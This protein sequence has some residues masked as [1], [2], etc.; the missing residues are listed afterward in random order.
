MEE[1][2]R[3]QQGWVR[4]GLGRESRFHSKYD[5]GFPGGSDSKESIL[6]AGE[7]GSIPRSGRSLEKG[8]A[9]HSHILAWKTP[10][11][12]ESGGTQSIG[13]QREDTTERLTHFKYDFII[14][15]IP[16]PL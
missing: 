16:F 1:Q 7:P 14:C 15:V 3:S 10:W 6:N 8:M 13:L 9:S 11:T 4:H 12:E 5:L 2:G